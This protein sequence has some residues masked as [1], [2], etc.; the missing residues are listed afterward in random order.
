LD[1]GP[2]NFCESF[3]RVFPKVSKGVLERDTKQLEDLSHATDEDVIKKTLLGCA[4]AIQRTL[5]LKS[6]S[7]LLSFCPQFFAKI[8]YLQNHLTFMTGDNDIFVN[9]LEHFEFQMELIYQ[10]LLTKL[11]K[12]ESQKGCCHD[13]KMNHYYHFDKSV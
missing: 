9:T 4:S 11:P 10:F 5:T 2:A 13:W 7:S 1:S 8:E 12:K 6:A 3:I